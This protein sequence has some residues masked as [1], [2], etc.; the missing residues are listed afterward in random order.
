MARSKRKPAPEPQ[1]DPT[2]THAESAG[3]T[4]FDPEEFDPEMKPNA[5]TINAAEAAGLPPADGF[6]AQNAPRPHIAN[7][8]SKRRE[9]T[10][11]ARKLPGTLGVAAGELWVR[12]IDAGSNAAGIGIRVETPDGR[13]LTDGEKDIV[14]RHVRGE[15]GEKTGYS[16]DQDNRMW[17]KP[18]VRAGEHPAAVPPVRAIAI[19]LD[20][21]SRVLKLAEALR[22]HA[23]DPVG[24]AAREQQRRE[25]AAEAE[26]IPD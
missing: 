22:D 24:F 4:S 16:W 17:H 20:A 25:Q 8:S 23:A 2:S 14:R 1:T 7:P 21:E 18:I 19:R 11:S 5:V 26:R 10:A 15:D 6:A 9:F 12:L 13:T 3:D